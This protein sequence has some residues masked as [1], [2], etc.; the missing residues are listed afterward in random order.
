VR[1]KHT[2]NAAYIQNAFRRHRRRRNRRMDRML[3][4]VFELGEYAPR[5][6]RRMNRA[7][8]IQAFGTPPPRQRDPRNVWDTPRAAGGGNELMSQRGGVRPGHPN[9]PNVYDEHVDSLRGRQN[10]NPHWIGSRT[11][12]R[13]P[14]ITQQSMENFIE[15]HGG[16]ANID[17]RTGLPLRR[18]AEGRGVTNWN[19]LGD[20]DK[21]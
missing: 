7:N 11:N 9:I 2:L 17:P 16:P 15:R 13:D 18:D 10:Q 14:N 4:E 20:Y 19:F 21:H 3:D 6:R 12:H 8:V 1:A 5:Q